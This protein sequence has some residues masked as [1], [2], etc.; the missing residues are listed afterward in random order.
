MAH[1]LDHHNNTFLNA[2]TSAKG[3]WV[4]KLPKAVDP[5][6][7]STLFGIMGV[8]AGGSTAGTANN[9]GSL[10]SYIVRKLGVWL[11]EDESDIKAAEARFMKPGQ[12]ANGMSTSKGTGAAGPE[13]VANM[14]PSDLKKEGQF[15]KSLELK[16]AL[17]NFVELP[18][19]DFIVGDNGR[20]AVQ[21]LLRACPEF[22]PNVLEL[23]K[24]SPNLLTL[25]EAEI[26]KAYE[27][28]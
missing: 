28:V 16:K 2:N 20:K 19:R 27:I 10:A 7:S 3:S 12:Q 24:L 15:F 22:L 6:E 21:E 26:Q 9:S 17:T 11:G 5:Q 14:L 8:G 18:F 23:S 4:E 25:E 13:I 1:R